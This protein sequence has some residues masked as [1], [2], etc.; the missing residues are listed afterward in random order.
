MKKEWGEIQEVSGLSS[1]VVESLSNAES[2]TRETA[3]PG[4]KGALK[5]PGISYP[6]GPVANL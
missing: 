5:K 6:P 2:M 3:M 4:P 1:H